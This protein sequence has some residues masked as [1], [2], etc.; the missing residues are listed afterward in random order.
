[1]VAVVV[2]TPDWGL[3]VGVP[4]PSTLRPS[5][6]GWTL[7]RPPDP[8]DGLEAYKRKRSKLIKLVPQA[9]K[10]CLTLKFD[11]RRFQFIW[12]VFLSGLALS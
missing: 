6:D 4:S 11:E 10:K 2:V 8:M 1:M 12:L 7:A 9:Y 3:V 5:P